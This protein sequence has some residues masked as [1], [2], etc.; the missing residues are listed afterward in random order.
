MRF[1]EQAG[2]SEIDIQVCNH[3]YLLAD[4]LRRTDSK[5]PLI[6]NYQSV[7][8]DEAHKFLSAVR[9][10]YG[11]ELSCSEPFEIEALA[12]GI[13]FKSEPKQ[14][15]IYNVAGKLSNVSARLFRRLE[16][17][18]VCEE[19]EEETDHFY[20]EFDEDNHRLIKK[21]RNIS[22]ELIELIT[23]EPVTGKNAERK[24]QLLWQLGEIGKQ[25]AAFVWHDD[26]ICWL[27]KDEKDCRLCAIPK[28]LDKRLYDD[29]WSKGIPTI[30]TS[31]TLSAAGDF[32][33]IKRTLG[34]ERVGK[35]RLTETSKPPP[36]NYREN[37]LIY[38]SENMP[39]PDRRDGEYIL[40]V[41][42]EVEQ[43]IYA[44]HGHAAVLFTSYRAMDMVLEHL[45][46]RGIPF[47][48]FRLDK[49]SIREIDRFKKS[50]NGVL[51]AA[52]ALWEGIDI[53]GD[54]LSMLI[55]VKLPF[56]VPDPV[57]EYEQTLYKN[58]AKYKECVINPEMLIKNKQGYGR[59]IRIESDTC[60]FAFLDCRVSKKGSYRV[61][62][63]NS[64]PY[65]PVTDSM[66]VVENFYPEKKS[67]NYFV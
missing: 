10:M 47:P 55:L 42:N 13:N 67:A 30:L 58:M 56:A 1:R 41:A 48:F 49:G 39:F 44:S 6:P 50:G 29:L 40:A 52:E 17:L 4:T 14:D 19:T 51:F 7:I 28:D 11:I 15:E 37:A 2:A 65:C 66:T 61:I 21:I 9:S 27:E 18:A 38:I 23:A 31:G 59:G 35:S 5:H 25:A 12:N 57:G 8:I 22:D 20:A 64:L 45:E 26:Y 46:E 62:M 54:T 24:K 34:I 33:H 3:N 43:L 53:P 60:V 16:E 36:F 63:L 32:S